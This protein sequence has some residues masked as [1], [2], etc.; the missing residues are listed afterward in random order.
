MERGKYG[1]SEQCIL[2][3]PPSGN[4]KP[5]GT[6]LLGDP[7][8]PPRYGQVDRHNIQAP[9]TNKKIQRN[10]FKGFEDQ[11]DTYHDTEIDYPM[12]KYPLLL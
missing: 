12:E 10:I 2:I 3:N 7:L 4:S 11:S 9:I 5:M 8:I 1:G 6:S